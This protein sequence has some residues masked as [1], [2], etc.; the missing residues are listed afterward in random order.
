MERDREMESEREMERKREERKR[1][2]NGESREREMW[3]ERRGHACKIMLT[4]SESHLSHHVLFIHG[5]CS[6][7]HKRSSQAK[8]WRAHAY[9]FIHHVRKEGACQY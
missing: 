9:Q 5:T 2:R 6:K 8:E 7:M 3:R 4:N 1:E